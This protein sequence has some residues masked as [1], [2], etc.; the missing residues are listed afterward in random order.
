MH[1]KTNVFKV[2]KTINKVVL[3]LEITKGRTAK[4]PQLF[5]Q[6]LLKKFFVIVGY[7]FWGHKFKL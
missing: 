1:G 3:L 5:G 6:T 2:K 4:T 7:L